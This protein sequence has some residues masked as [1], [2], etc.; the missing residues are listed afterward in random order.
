MSL[1][2]AVYVLD[3]ATASCYSSVRASNYFLLAVYRGVTPLMR[4][5]PPLLRATFP[6]NYLDSGASA[7]AERCIC[8]LWKCPDEIPTGT[9]FIV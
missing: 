3:G 7:Q 2:G 5:I 8:L 9:V 6:V 1:H 4:S